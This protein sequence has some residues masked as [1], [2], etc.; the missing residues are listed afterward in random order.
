MKNFSKLRRKLV[1][2][3]WVAPIISS[4][5]LPAHA[6]TSPTTT[7]TTTT[8]PT[9]TPLTLQLNCSAGSVGTVFDAN[10]SIFTFTISGAITATPSVADLSGIMVSIEF[11]PGDTY[12]S[13]I[14]NTG[15]GNIVQVTTA[16]D[17]TFSTVVM[18]AQWLTTTADFVCSGLGY[19]MKLVSASSFSTNNPSFA[20]ELAST[21]CSAPSGCE[22]RPFN[23]DIRLKTDITPLGQTNE[24][25]SLYRF[26]Y[27]NDKNNVEY[28]GVMAQD[29]LD[30]HPEAVVVKESGFYGVYYDRLNLRMTTYSDWIRDG[31]ESVQLH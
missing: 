19:E 18:L 11:G 2:T 9:P 28:V 10:T 25:F 4:I 27:L 5:T 24:G 7:P 1:I 13:D 20:V 29:L 8:T 14:G 6:A 26:K 22:T 15:P 31:L 17:G 30:T 16:A 12:L 21:S 23:S 3:T